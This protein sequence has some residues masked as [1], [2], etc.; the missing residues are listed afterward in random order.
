MAAAITPY[1]RIEQVEAEGLANAACDVAELYDIPALSQETIAWGNLVQ[2]LAFV[3]GS[4]IMAYRA[5]AARQRGE[6]G[7][8]AGADSATNKGSLTPSPD[9]PR[10]Q[11]I[12]PVQPASMKMEFEGLGIIDVPTAP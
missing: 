4:R 11:P 12:Q 9:A 7:K 3:Y 2:T 8:V 1:L 6:R 5:D 10:A